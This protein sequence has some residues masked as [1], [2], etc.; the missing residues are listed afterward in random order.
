M[1]SDTEILGGQPPVA[2]NFL[3]EV[4]GVAIGTFQKVSGLEVTV[5]THEYAEGGVSGFVHR[6][7]GQMSWP[8]LVFSRGLTTSDN[9][10]AWMNRS[11]GDGFQSAGGKLERKTASVTLIDVTGNRLR[12]FAVRD[13]FPVRWTGPALATQDSSV[14]YEELEVAHHGFTSAT[15]V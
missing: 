14:L 7:P 10:F 11:A 4:D 13:A 15:F 12:S 6:L 8:S 2:A 9:L 1:P 3:L 5:A